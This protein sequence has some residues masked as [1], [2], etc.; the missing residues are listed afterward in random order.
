MVLTAHARRTPPKYSFTL[1]LGNV[2]VFALDVNPARVHI[3]MVA[4]KKISVGTTHWHTWPCDIA[5]EDNRNLSHRQWLNEFCHR[6]KILT[7]GLS[8]AKP[9]FEGGEQ[10]RMR[11]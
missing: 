5:D 8:C 9:P 7:A 2:R 6:C 1:L 11:L 4:G 3:N 10:L